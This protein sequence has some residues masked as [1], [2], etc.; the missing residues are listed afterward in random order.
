MQ[1]SSS[2]VDRI[3]GALRLDPATY[4]EV[5]HDSSAT[6]Q[7]VAVVVIAVILSGIGAAQRGTGAII[8]SVILALIAWVVYTFAVYLVG[9]TILKSPQTSATFEQ[10]LRPLG[11]AYAPSALGILAFIPGVG[12]IISLLAG[13]WSLVASIVAI[14]Q[15]LEV[16][17]GRAVGIAIVAVIV[18]AVILAIV[19]TIFGLSLYGLESLTRPT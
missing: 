17:T 11:F 3:V 1:Q 9:T 15:S 19:G 2:I 5:E 8:S 18:I 10:V 4:E 16:S 13:I 12:G 7:A 6:G 14:R